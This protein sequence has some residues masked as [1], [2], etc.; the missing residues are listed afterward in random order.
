MSAAG[1]AIPSSR[2]PTSVS[3]YSSAAGARSTPAIAPVGVERAPAALEYRETEVAVLDDGIARPAADIVDCGAADQAHGAMH[4]DG[5]VLV[6]LDHAHV[7]EPGVLAVHRV[8]HDAAVAVA[9]VLRRLHEPHRRIGESRDQVPEPP[10][11]DPVTR[12]DHGDDFRL[13][14]RV[15][16]RQPQRAGLESRQLVDAHELEAIAEPRAMLF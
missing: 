2:T 15:G 7:E 4:D 10:R 9:M 16:E 13:R 11:I 8:M 14:R 12:V 5:I 6:A 1:R 3:R